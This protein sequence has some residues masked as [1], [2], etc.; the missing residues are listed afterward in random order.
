MTVWLDCANRVVLPWGI[1]LAPNQRAT[2]AH[3]GP[4]RRR[5]PPSRHLRSCLAGKSLRR[6]GLATTG[7]WPWLPS[8]PHGRKPRAA[9]IHDRRPMPPSRPRRSCRFAGG[10]FCREGGDAFGCADGLEWLFFLTRAK[11]CH[12]GG[13]AFGHQSTA[14]PI[15]IAGAQMGSGGA[16]TEVMAPLCGARK[17]PDLQE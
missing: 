16:I 8:C 9:G 3:P 13:I 1:G 7:A 4:C 12:N 2:S 14:P 15:Q 11:Y 6:R 17:I 10:M 5:S